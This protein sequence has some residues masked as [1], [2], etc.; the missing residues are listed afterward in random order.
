MNLTRLFVEWSLAGFVTAGLIAS[1]QKGAAKNTVA[2]AE[3]AA[4]KSSV[5]QE[6][7]KAAAAMSKLTR[8]R[9]LGKL[10]PNPSNFRTF[11]LGE[12]LV[13]S[14]DDPE[15]WEGIGEGSRHSENSRWQQRS[16]GSAQRKTTELDWS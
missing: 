7:A 2:A 3:E 5:N 9:L 15:Y 8:Q 13:E 11:S 10:P 12:V 16:I 1:A 14:E 4:P 6:P